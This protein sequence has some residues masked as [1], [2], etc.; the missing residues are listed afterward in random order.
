MSKKLY[1]V[2]NRKLIKNGSLEDKIKSSIKGGA[3][4]IIL[5][6]KDLSEK[7]LYEITIKIL[8]YM[9]GNIP[10]IINESYK[11]GKISQTAGIHLSYESFMNFDKQYNKLLGV[12]IHSLEE[13]IAVEN[14]G[15]DYVIAGHIYNTSCKKGV[16]GRGI[17][18]LENICSVLTIPVIAI[19]GVNENNVK[20]VLKCGADGIAVM[21]SVMESEN[22]EKVVYNLKNTINKMI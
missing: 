15:A 18:F 21:S 9:D 5:R 16:P 8:E 6:E 1:V 22:A 7:E 14:K 11:V 19:G 4:A 13:G 17:T 12:S 3:D 2:T 10:L 20:E